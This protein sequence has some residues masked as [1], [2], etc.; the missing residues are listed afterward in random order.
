M[1]GGSF[2]KQTTTT[3]TTIRMTTKKNKLEIW[4]K[5][6][7]FQSYNV[8]YATFKANFV[9]SLKKIVYRGPLSL[10][11]GAIARL[12]HSL[13]RCKNL[14]AQHRSGV[15]I[16]FSEKVDL[17]GY[18]STSR[19]SKLVDQSSPDFFRLTREKSR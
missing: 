3:T 11:G 6:F 19:P 17:G 14:G 13:S 9:P 5:A 8:S 10:V 12:G 7:K 2:I 15:K 4:G 18:N 1:V 16:W